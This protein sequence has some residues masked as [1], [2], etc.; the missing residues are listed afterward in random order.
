MVRDPSQPVARKRKK[1]KP[2]SFGIKT[3]AFVVIVYFF[4][5]PLIPGFRNAA[6]ELL[7]VRPDL[8]FAGLALQIGAWW[9]YSMLTMAALGDA[10]Q[11]ISK[12]RMFRIQ[13]STKALSNIVPGGSAAGSALAYRLMTLSGVR[14]ADAGFALATAGLGSAVVLNLL[15]WSALTV[16]IPVR[17]VNRLYASAALAGVVVML[18]AAGLVIGLVHGQGRAERI[19]K[20]IARK[21]RFDGD[22]AAAALRQ[23]GTRVEELIDDRQLLKRVVFWTIVNWVLD[24]MSLWVF[25]RAFGGSLAPDALFV[26]FGLANVMA[27]IP[28][29][30]GGLGIVEGVYI[31]TLV[32]FNLRRS[33]ATL[34]VAA[35]RITQL[36]LPIAVGAFF[37]ATLR[38]GPWSIERRDR[39]ERM[40]QLAHDAESGGESRVDFLMRVW[41]KRVVRSMSR[42]DV[43]PEEAAEQERAEAI[44]AI[45]HPEDHGR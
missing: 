18:V 39:L 37:Y 24:A 23:V 11:D 27:V 45:E 36:F 32:G 19:L 7:H 13:M 34:G 2:L 25:L 42:V 14:G 8:L 12:M 44:D 33:V 3:A 22:R 28:F 43:T 17:G 26:A 31:P 41:P 21:F 30:P 35:Y 16:S 15:F 10:G 1:F 6:T 9:A 38:I 40:R 29:T 4:V 20:W 5:L